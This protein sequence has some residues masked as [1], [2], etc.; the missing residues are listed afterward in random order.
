MRGQEKRTGTIHLRHE[1]VSYRITVLG[2]VNSG[3]VEMRAWWIEVPRNAV[4]LSLAAA[5]STYRATY[6]ATYITTLGLRGTSEGGYVLL[7]NQ[8]AVQAIFKF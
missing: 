8:Y 5:H 1:H 4:L 7:L 6:R 3:W 2:P